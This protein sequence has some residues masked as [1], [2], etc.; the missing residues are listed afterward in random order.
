MTEIAAN[1]ALKIIEKYTDPIVKKLVQISQAEWEKFKIDINISFAN[2]LENSYS[3]YSKIKTILYRTEP[4]YIYDFFEVPYLYKSQ[5]KRFLANGIDKLLDISNFLIIE[6]TGGIGKSTLMKHLFINA[7][8]QNILIP[9]FFDLK[10]IN[11]V[12]HNYSLEDLFFQKLENLG[13]TIKRDFMRYALEGGCFIFLLDGY[14]EIITS[15]QDSFFRLFDDFCDRYPNNH[16]IISSRPYSEFVEFQRFTVLKSLPLTQKQSISLIKKA[17]FDDEIKKR[18]ILAL[19]TKL[20]E[21][22]ESFASNPLLLNIMLMTFD[23][24]AEIPEKL[25]LFYANA[26]ETLYSKHDATKSGFKRE[27]HSKLT[28]DSFRSIFSYLCFI[29]YSQNKYEFSFDDLITTLKKIEAIT[30]SFDCEAYIYDLTNSLCVIY[31]DGLNYKFTHR[32]FQE[33]FTAFFLKELPDSTMGKYSIQLINRNDSRIRHDEVFSMLYDMTTQRFEKSI[34]IPLLT[35]FEE[36]C[37]TEKKYD[38]YFRKTIARIGYDDLHEFKKPEKS[39]KSRDTEL[40][41]VFTHGD[42]HLASFLCHYSFPYR[43]KSSMADC[44]RAEIEL[45]HYLREDSAFTLGILINYDE[46]IQ[47]TRIYELLRKT[48]IGNAIQT[49]AQLNEYLRKK[50]KE[51][52]LDLSLLIQ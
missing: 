46:I 7:L 35:K 12:R 20:Y 31:K 22:H 23:N 44:E 37:I 38:F 4:Q 5:R 21:T 47:D 18:F 34:L 29:T 11:D 14:D 3:K 50:H 9:V 17:N 28:Y 52:E 49:L 48:W 45:F 10:E 8:S 1:F 36:S 41:L 27:M 24:Y 42:N 30:F 39:K 26:F 25:H 43:D 33:Y 40:D 32:S 19:K 6:G 51:N 13:S 2:Y 16:Y 15:K